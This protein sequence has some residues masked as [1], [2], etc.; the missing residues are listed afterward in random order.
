M[1]TY[2][3]TLAMYQAGNK[4]A[5]FRLYTQDTTSVGAN[6]QKFCEGMDKI[7]KRGNINP[8]EAMVTYTNNR[9]ANWYKNAKLDYGVEGSGKCRV[10]GNNFIV[11]FVENGISDVWQM[12]FYPEYI[13]ENTKD[14]FYNCWCEGTK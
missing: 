4:A 8:T 12:A 9:I 11:E 3:R 14:Y 7:L 2:Q 13:E 5:A 1:T 10:E 6:F